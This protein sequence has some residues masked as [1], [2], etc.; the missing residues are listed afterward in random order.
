MI[1]KLKYFLSSIGEYF[2]FSKSE[3]QALYFLTG[4]II[5]V[6]LL[7]FLIPYLQLKSKADINRFEEEIASLNQL[8]GEGDT[9]SENIDPYLED[10]GY[11]PIHAFYFDPNKV[12]PPEWEKLGVPSF[13]YQRIE[14]Y[15]L[16]G[17]KIRKTEDLLKFSG[18]DRQWYENI[19]DFVR[20]SEKADTFKTQPT[21]PGFQKYDLNKVTRDE[22]ISIKGIGEVL[23][24]RIINYREYL[25]GFYTLEQ[26][27]EVYG[28]DSLRFNYLKKYFLLNDIS[29]KKISLNLSS[30]SQLSKHPYLTYHQ[31][32][33]IVEFRNKT[34]PFHS[35]E[36]LRRTNIYQDSAAY[37]KL[38]PY[39]KLWDND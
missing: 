1:K 22:L 12:G 34:G 38:F 4:I 13:I 29:V 5:I 11:K 3:R 25:G 14:K 23:A 8:S 39:L 37:N 10:I 32:E 27:A 17:G 9:N 15:K 20:F 28:I 30:V 2:S 24:D 36:E 21:S 33:K 18:F 16:K 26:L 35:L 7:N 6:S 31:A 19:K